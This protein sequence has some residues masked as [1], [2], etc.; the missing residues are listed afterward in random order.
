MDQL[1][2]IEFGCGYYFY[3]YYFAGVCPPPGS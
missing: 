3:W 2:K 1:E